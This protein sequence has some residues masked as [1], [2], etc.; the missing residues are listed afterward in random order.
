M[1]EIDFLKK[2]YP[3][4]EKEE[5]CKRLNR[6]WEAIQAKAIRLGIFREVRVN[7]GKKN[8]Q[9]KGGIN[10][11]YYR[12]IAFET[13]PHYCAVCGLRGKLEVHHKDKNR[14]NNSPE[15]LMIVCPKCHGN[16]H[17]LM[18]DWA[19]DFD[20]CI[21]CGRTDRKHNAHGMCIICYEKVYYSKVREN[22]TRRQMRRHQK[23]QPGTK[24]M[25]KKKK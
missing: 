3:N 16:I 21:I 22:K 8:G 6:S 15:N 1:E 10:E 19:T 24:R 7:L 18:N 25:H 13:Y 17:Y 5:I 23:Y 9:W 12:R 11:R 20:S 2:N 4:S 14:K